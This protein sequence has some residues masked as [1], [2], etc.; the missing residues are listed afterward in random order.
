[1]SYF[2]VKHKVTTLNCFYNKWILVNC[3]FSV[4]PFLV[5]KMTRYLF[6]MKLTL[7]TLLVIGLVDGLLGCSSTYEYH[8]FPV[9]E[10]IIAKCNLKA[11][12]DMECYNVREQISC[13]SCLMENIRVKCPKLPYYVEYAEE[14]HCRTLRECIFNMDF[15]KCYT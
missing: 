1:M 9:I 14:I 6:Q 15:R 5:L 10:G 3:Y 12:V 8:P 4:K 2:A 13:H 7:L 11:K